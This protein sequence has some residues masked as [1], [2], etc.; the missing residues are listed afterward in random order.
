[1]KWTSLFAL[2]FL[3][4]VQVIKA[5]TPA[6]AWPASAQQ[7]GQFVQEKHLVVLTQPFITKGNYHYQQA[8]GLTWH[9]LEPMES[10]IKITT[11]GVSERQE[12]GGF[13]TLTNNSQFSE[14]LLALFNG[15]KTSLQQQFSLE[16]QPNTLNLI[17]KDPQIAKVILKITLHI[18]DN[19]IS[20]IVLYEA[21]GNYTNIF[22]SPT[23]SS[24]NKD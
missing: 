8:T 21:E 16:Q 7:Q 10:E 15:E 24:V 2:F 23:L 17:P 4:Q 11:E 13:K 5:E 22:L 20:Q 14:L 1:M 18:S 12:D 6:F 3:Y 19:V 9:T